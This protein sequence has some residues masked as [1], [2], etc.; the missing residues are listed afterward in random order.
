MIFA[1]S[2]PFPPLALNSELGVRGVLVS[3]ASLESIHLNLLLA[4]SLSTTAAGNSDTCALWLALLSE[5]Q[6]NCA[7][8][9][10]ETGVE[11]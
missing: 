1:S 9:W 10:P 11:V 6:A 3:H 4:A 5:Q 2:T 7:N 8:K